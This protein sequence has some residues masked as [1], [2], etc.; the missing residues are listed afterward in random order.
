MVDF[1]SEPGVLSD[2]VDHLPHIPVR[3]FQTWASDS[4][5]PQK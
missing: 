2:D 5:S 3:F 4:F 1:A